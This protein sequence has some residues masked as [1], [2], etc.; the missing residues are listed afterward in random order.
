MTG[1]ADPGQAA[2]AEAEMATWL[3][4]PTELGA[5]PDEIEL[6]RTVEFESPD[7]PVDLFVFRFRTHQPHWAA[8]DGWMIGVAGPYLRSLQP[9]THGL[10][11]TFSKLDGEDEMPIVDHV[12]GLLEIVAGFAESR[13]D[14]GD[15]G[16]S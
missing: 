10:G 7:G 15:A 13:R 12:N 1:Q 6:L 11:Y 16:A 3:A 5:A 8:E 4:Y 9:T 2:I 14:A